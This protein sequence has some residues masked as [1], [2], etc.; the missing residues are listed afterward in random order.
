MD[1]AEIARALEARARQTLPSLYFDAAHYDLLAQMTAPADLPFYQRLAQ[2]HGGPILEL[3]AGT[4][5]IATALAKAGHE[6]VG[7]ELSSAMLE[8]AVARAQAEGVE[9]TYALGDMRSFD[10]GRTFPLILVPFNALNHLLDDDSLAGALAAMRAHMDD[11]SRLVIDTFQPSPAFLGDAPERRR[12]ILR[13]RDPY[14]DEEVLLSEEN[15]YDPA[16]QLNRIVWSYAVG[17]VEDARVEELTMRLFWPRELDAWLRFAGLRLE[18]KLGDY[19]GR[20]FDGASPKQIVV[21]RR[22]DDP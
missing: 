1:E 7:L 3:G 6:V 2:A 17:G 11:G 16:T 18:E 5:R 19:D 12:P 4:G 13:Y 14:L 9:V 10:L 15:H 21:A 22:A 20:P 8:T